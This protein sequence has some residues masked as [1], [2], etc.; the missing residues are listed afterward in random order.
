MVEY[1]QESNVVE[2]LVFAYHFGNLV[3][4][5]KHCIILINAIQ[6]SWGIVRDKLA[7]VLSSSEVCKD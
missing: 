3:F 7:T 1:H 6:D 2:S 4:S 5:G